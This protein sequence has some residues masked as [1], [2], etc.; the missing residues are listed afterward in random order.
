MLLHHGSAV[1]R[2][3]LE[4]SRRQILRT[5]RPDQNKTQIPQSP[6]ISPILSPTPHT[7]ISIT[8]THTLTHIHP[9]LAP[10]HARVL[11]TYPAHTHGRGTLYYPIRPRTNR[12]S[13]Y[14]ILVF[15][16]AGIHTR[17]PGGVCPGAGMSIRAIH[18]VAMSILSISITQAKFICYISTQI[19]FCGSMHPGATVCLPQPAYLPHNAFSTIQWRV[20]LV[21][22]TP[23][24]SKNLRIPFSPTYLIY[25]TYTVSHTISSYIHTPLTSTRTTYEH[26]LIR[27]HICSHL[28]RKTCCN[29]QLCLS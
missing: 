17:P 4:I 9:T 11:Y 10:T 21:G 5:T 20:S 22:D 29:G 6:T 13:L 16:C 25:L 24:L 23:F 14:A 8:T 3:S 12:P 19:E 26:P 18:I 2:T 28:H 1:P 27:L 7:T 15:K